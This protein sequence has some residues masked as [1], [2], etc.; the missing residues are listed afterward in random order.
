M[1]GHSLG[2]AAATLAAAHVR[3]TGS[4]ADLYSFSSPRVGDPAFARYVGG[5]DG[6]SG[7][8]Y[9]VTH[10][11]DWVPKVPL[12]AM[13]YLHVADEYWISS[14]NGVNV[15][16]SDVVVFEGYEGEDYD[17]GNAGTEKTD[18]TFQTHEWI[19]DK[20]TLCYPKGTIE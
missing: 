8:N 15:T 17:G 16:T 4:H 12:K 18:P 20:I 5:Q 6:V 1:I 14:P 9:R 19:F 10:R 11:D 3:N 2:A 13:G 7:S